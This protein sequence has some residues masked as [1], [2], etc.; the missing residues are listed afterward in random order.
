MKNWK[1]KVIDMDT[2]FQKILKESKSPNELEDYI[3]KTYDLAGLTFIRF[4]AQIYAVSRVYYF[5]L[6]W[7]IRNGTLCEV[8]REKYPDFVRVVE[9]IQSLVGITLT[10]ISTKPIYKRIFET[11]LFYIVFGCNF[12]RYFFNMLRD[13][14][15]CAIAISI[16]LYVTFMVIY[17]LTID[18]VHAGIDS[19]YMTILKGLRII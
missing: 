6:N 5:D 7:N 9:V 16:V 15:V 2:E 3:K 13:Y 11:V 12:V 19:L 1:R 17:I 4:L 14:P 18:Q 10:E 8:D